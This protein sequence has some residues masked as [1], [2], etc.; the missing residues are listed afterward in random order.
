MLQIEGAKT[1]FFGGGGVKH[2]KTKGGAIFG[3]ILSTFWKLLGVL[4]PP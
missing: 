4:K 3:M 2:A 1:F